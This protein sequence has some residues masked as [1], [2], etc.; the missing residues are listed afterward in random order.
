MTFRDNE[1]K[2]YQTLKPRLFSPAANEPGTYNHIPRDFCLAD[3]HAAENLHA[4]FREDAIAYFSQRGISW[5]DGSPDER[6]HARGLPSNHLCCSQCA[7]VNALWP[8]T[9]QP[10]A[11]A[12]VFRPFFPDLAEAL[13]FAADDPLPD[14][15]QPLLAFEWIGQVGTNYLGE[16]GHRSR[17]ANATSADFA[18]RFRRYD[19]RIQLVLGEW[20]YTEHYHIHEPN[21]KPTQ[22]RVYRDAFERWQAQQ[23]DLP[24]YHLLFVEPFYQL[25]RLTLLAQ[26]ME[27]ARIDGAGEMGTDVVSALVVAPRANR[28]YTER[29]TVPAFARYGRTVGAAW[30][31]LAPPGRFAYLPT[32]SL[33]TV[34]DQV[35][36]EPLGGWRDY[37]LTRYGWWRQHKTATEQ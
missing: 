25:M 6:G 12:N 36:P 1:K 32:E 15:T 33:L 3:D 9:R 20:K 11:L 34:I 28:D 35:A 30:A 23:P 17:G 8:L 19:G 24:E 2:R 29:F 16:V 37:L 5:H 27:Q 14:G 21:P 13:P 22:L 7:C 31:H 18:F 26:A 4:S 10:H